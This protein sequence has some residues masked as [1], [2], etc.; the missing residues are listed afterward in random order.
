MFNFFFLSLSS[1]ASGITSTYFY[2]N[3][4]LIWKDFEKKRGYYTGYVEDMPY[5]G[6]FNW[7]GK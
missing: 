1:L 4:P 7:V 2:D 3:Q 6:I 5:Y